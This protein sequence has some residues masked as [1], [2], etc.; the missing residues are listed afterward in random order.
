MPDLPAEQ[1]RE[2]GQSRALAPDPRRGLTGL[3]RG[4]LLRQVRRLPLA[5][6]PHR[7]PEVSHSPCVLTQAERALSFKQVPARRPQASCAKSPGIGISASL[8]SRSANFR[9]A[10]RS[11]VSIHRCRSSSAIGLRRPPI[12]GPTF[13]PG[14]PRTRLP[15]SPRESSPSSLSGPSPTRPGRLGWGRRRHRDVLCIPGQGPSGSCGLFGARQWLAQPVDQRTTMA[16]LRPSTTWMLSPKSS[17]KRRS[18][19]ILNP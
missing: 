15:I 18:S 19:F 14:A 12:V 3:A 4:A 7:V 8:R 6:D 5:P 17:L 13:Q 10:R 1:R 9:E 16:G 2:Q 11:S